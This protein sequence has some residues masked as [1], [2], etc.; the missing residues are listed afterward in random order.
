MINLLLSLKET[1]KYSL[2][3]N[4]ALLIFLFICFEILLEVG[5][6]ASFIKE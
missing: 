6:V 5:F 4:C 1:E 3:F 2:S